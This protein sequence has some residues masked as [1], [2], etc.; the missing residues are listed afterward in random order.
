M[1]A[2][3]QAI[4]LGAAVLIGD[5]QRILRVARGVAGREVHGLEVVEV[6]FDLGADADGV[7]EGRE[8]GDDFVQRF[9]DRVLGAGEAAG[10]GQGD[11][12]GFGGEGG[13]APT[14]VLPAPAAASSRLS[15]CC[16]RALKRWPRDFLASAGRGLEVARGDF[17]EAALLAAQ[18]LEAEG[19]NGIGAAE[20]GG[21][22]GGL[23][24]EGGEG[25]VERVVVKGGQSR[26]CVVR[27]CVSNRINHPCME[28]FV[29]GLA[30]C[31]AKKR[32]T[33]PGGRVYFLTA[34]SFVCFAGVG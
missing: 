6:G 17:V 11:V 10:A 2:H 4:A 31:G 15:T 28:L 1:G 26:N 16:L 14:R 18:P 24:L 12:D 21:S 30:P 20:R 8:D 7:A 19:F 32:W 5:D 13:V 3:E 22:G 34:I 23:L 9:R 25:L 29:R 27:H 33:H